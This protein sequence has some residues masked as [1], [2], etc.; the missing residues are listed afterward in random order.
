[1]LHH[2]EHPGHVEVG[3]LL[4]FAQIGFE[5]QLVAR[6]RTRVVDQQ[7]DVEI[8]GVLGDSRNRL[9]IQQIHRDRAHLDAELAALVGSIGQRPGLAGDQHQVESVFGE[10]AGKLGAYAFGTRFNA[11]GVFDQKAPKSRSS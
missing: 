10:L 8:G 6:A 4:K 7:P 9:W 2:L 5:E 1:M 3:D 11:H